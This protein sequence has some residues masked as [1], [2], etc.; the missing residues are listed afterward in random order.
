L[1]SGLY[2]S[3]HC[4]MENMQPEAP[5]PA[6][7]KNFESTQTM[8]EKLGIGYIGFGSHCAQSH[9][10]Y[11]GS[12]PL[13]ETVGVADLRPV[14]V[15]TVTDFVTDPLITTDYRELLDDDRVQAV[16]ITTR[17]DTHYPITKDA[18]EAGKH[19]LVEKPAAATLDE[20]AALPDLF[21]LASAKGLKLWVCHS[22]E[23]GEGPWSTAA[24]LISDP[25]RISE[26]FTVGPMGRLRELRHD[27][28]YTVPGRQG[29]HTSFAD[30]KLN[31]TIVS[32]QRSLPGIAGFRNAVL[33]DN[34][35]THYDAR[36]VVASDNEAQDGVVVRASGR[37]SAHEEHHGGGV[38]RD[39]I[40]AVFDEGVLRIEPSLGRI[41]LTYGKKEKTP[42]EFDPKRLYDDTFGGIN[43]EFVRC[44]LDTQRPEPL[45]SRVMLLGTAAAI[46]MQQPGFNGEITEQAVRQLTAEGRPFQS[47]AHN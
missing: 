27:C 12:S 30:D 43:T 14:N 2:I 25:A 13:Y 36:L 39:W 17:D 44:S 3:Y 6:V 35:P 31:H 42:L 40:E 7:I 46:L 8:S 21:E 11:L 15:D 33:L 10:P 5:H 1:C 4:D 18:I 22:R 16:V 24:A 23:F 34:G 37:R 29:L 32:V 28:H 26:T 19:V 47:Q 45:P 41:A 38:W 9:V 20:L